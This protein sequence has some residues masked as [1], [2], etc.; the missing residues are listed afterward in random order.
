VR[1]G[2]ARLRAE[3][4]LTQGDLATRLGVSRQTVVS[5]ERGH[6]DPSLALALRIARTFGSTV[7]EVST[8]DE[9]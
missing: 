8:P 4:G 1:N 2:V 3:Q 7:E 5:I 9:E 6:H